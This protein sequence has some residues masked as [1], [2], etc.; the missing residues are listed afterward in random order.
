MRVCVPIRA[1]CLA[2][3]MIGPPGGVKKLLYVYRERPVVVPCPRSCEI[4]PVGR[5]RG[6]N[7]VFK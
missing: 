4:L 7:S 5:Y 6:G 3:G 1:R 2:V